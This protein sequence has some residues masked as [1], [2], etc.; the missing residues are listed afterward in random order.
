MTYCNASVPVGEHGASVESVNQKL[1]LRARER[2]VEIACAV[3]ANECNNDYLWSYT[4]VGWSVYLNL[5][6]FYEQERKLNPNWFGEMSAALSAE[7]IAIF[8]AAGWITKIEQQRRLFSSS[9]PMILQLNKPLHGSSPARCSCTCGKCACTTKANTATVVPEGVL[10][11]RQLKAR[12]LASAER[13]AASIAEQVQLND[14]N[15]DKVFRKGKSICF[16]MT[17]I[18]AEEKRKDPVWSGE[19]YEVQKALKRIFQER[20][21]KVDV[22]HRRRGAKPDRF[23]LCLEQIRS[24]ARECTCG[25]C[26]SVA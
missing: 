8:R 19:S 20:N 4:I 2:A 11:V 22:E 12:I 23:V 16:D 13:T 5:S 15:N 14:Y 24:D 10:T 25:K 21:F 3:S 7:L 1:L 18:L 9:K 26:S 17:D 6:S